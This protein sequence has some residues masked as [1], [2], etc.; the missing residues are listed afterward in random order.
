[1]T[2][3]ANATV[4]NNGC[5]NPANAHGEPDGVWTGNDDTSENWDCR[6]G[7]ENPD[8]DIGGTQT[9]TV[10]GRKSSSGGNGD[11]EITVDLYESGTFVANVVAATTI[12]STGGVDLSGT[13]DASVLSD[14][15]GAGV[16]ILLTVAGPGGMPAGR[17][18]IQIDAITFEEQFASSPALAPT[19][20]S[21]ADTSQD[22]DPTFTWQFN[23]DNAHLGAA[24]DAYA[25]RKVQLDEQGQPLERIAQTR[26]EEANLSRILVLDLSFSDLYIAIGHR[27]EGGLT[28]LNR[29]DWSEVSHGYV[30]TD[31]V[32]VGAPNIGGVSFS[33][34]GQYLAL[35]DGPNDVVVLDS[36][37]NWS[38]VA[39]A[40]PTFSGAD[41]SVYP[42]QCQFSP[43]GEWLVAISPNSPRVLVWQVSDWSLI[44]PTFSPSLSLMVGWPAW[45]PDNSQL[46]IPGRDGNSN[47][48]IW[49]N[50]TSTWST[51]FTRSA[52]TIIQS[53]AFN[54]AETVQLAMSHNNFGITTYEGTSYTRT[55]RPNIWDEDISTSSAG[56][57]PD[58]QYA[59]FGR[60]STSFQPKYLIASTSDWSQV[61]GNV[62]G[63]ETSGTRRAIAW[64]GDDLALGAGS[65][66]GLVVVRSG[67][68]YRYWDGSSWQLA[69]VLNVSAS[70]T[71]TPSSLVEGTTYLW[72][73]KTRETVTDLV[74]PYATS[75]E[76]TISSSSLSGTIDDSA[77]SASDHAEATLT[78]PASGTITD[79]A[80]LSSDHVTGS[81]SVTGDVA[82]VGLLP[83]DHVQG[84][85]VATSGVIS[86]VSPVARDLASGTSIVSGTATD[87]GLVPSDLTTAG[88]SASGLIDDQSP[89]SRDHIDGSKIKSGSIADVVPAPE[90]QADARVVVSGTGDDTTSVPT[91][92]MVGSST[93]TG[94]I[95]DS[96]PMA[97][98]L[99]DVGVSS[100]GS[101]SDLAPAAQD[102]VD[103][104]VVSLASIADVAPVPQDVAEAQ[105]TSSG[106]VDDLAPSP[107]DHLEG[108]VADASAGSITD[109]A[110]SSS[111]EVAGSIN[112]IASVQDDAPTSSDEVVGSISI[113]MA[114]YDN[115][116][117]GHDAATGSISI[118]AS[119]QDQAPSSTDS[120]SGS[121]SVTSSLDDVSPSPHEAVDGRV[122]V[123]ASA[124][125][126]APVAQD[127][128][129]G[130]AS[131]ATTGTVT[132]TAPV[133]SDHVEAVVN[134]TGTITDES[135]SAFDYMTAA[136]PSIGDITDIAPSSYDHITA[137]TGELRNITV[138]VLE[139]Y[140]KDVLVEA[141][142]AVMTTDEPRVV[143]QTDEPRAYIMTFGDVRADF[144]V[145]VP[146]VSI[147]IEGDPYT[148]LSADEPRL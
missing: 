48:T 99:V 6:W 56:F 84:G 32:S 65:D 35:T 125:D 69:E 102:V 43:N 94:E 108:A 58:G 27:Q 64:D 63:G 1:M 26:V 81:S 52:P 106:T 80:P 137:T 36:L 124:Q 12:S 24:Q 70:E 122:A 57:S 142:H 105:A 25:F 59:V 76:I 139:P 141:P 95:V 138:D 110:P 14:V 31:T 51:S 44:T 19:L 40:A 42:N 131:D 134:A 127:H 136:T 98:D 78:E 101:V 55:D 54:P 146:R 104:R 87:D 132:D 145:E 50:S 34:D 128:I 68:D 88:V 61:T 115:A 5:V 4:A 3:Y 72:S 133:G 28:I 15:S 29:S 73:V 117:S 13:F 66:D 140:I 23:T 16:E 30:P 97:T 67:L 135:P 130:S 109:I 126:E 74:G 118:T 39:I 60:G 93:T 89:V 129:E 53:I 123:T 143:I 100:T 17:R 71:L 82:D 10:R 9:I 21:P 147:H 2:L 45:R 90:D 41:T 20:V 111:D 79:A 91:D 47:W 96:P 119:V 120:I 62:S 148:Q 113:A 83:S 107:I 8:F 114:A 103:A 33:P 121:F 112:V 7:M 11:P 77:P 116:P 86:D 92:E 85:K 22:P 49:V 46:V 18:S 38:E 75:Y 144:V 37:N